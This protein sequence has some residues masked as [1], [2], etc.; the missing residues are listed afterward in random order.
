MRQDP[1]HEDDAA[2]PIYP[3]DQQ[4]LRQAGETGLVQECRWTPLPCRC[5]RLLQHGEKSSS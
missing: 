1:L 2:D 4:V 5:E 3:Q